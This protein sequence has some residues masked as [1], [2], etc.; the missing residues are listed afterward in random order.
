MG[1]KKV[2]MSV[3]LI[4]LFWLSPLAYL[5]HSMPDLAFV[6]T[7]LTVTPLIIVALKFKAGI[8]NS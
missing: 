5:A 4:N 2:T 8:T 6:L 3:I 7:L 1:H